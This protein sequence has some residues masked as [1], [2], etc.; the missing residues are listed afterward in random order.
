MNTNKRTIAVAELLL[1]LP[2]ALFMLALVMRRVQPLP[3]GLVQAAQR[4]VTWYAD[5]LW[6][7]WVLLVAMPFAVLIIG[8]A[9]LLQ[10]WE[11]EGLRMAVRQ[12]RAAM[13]THLAILSI[14]A[15]TCAAGGILSVVAL[16]ILAN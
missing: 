15:L 10:S 3:F 14:A 6:T 7:L 11:E 1:I 9:T 16:H 5:R 4:T 8:C 2:A 12:P 13:R